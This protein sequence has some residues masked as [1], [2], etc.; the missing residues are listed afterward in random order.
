[1]AARPLR[2]LV[3]CNDRTC[4]ICD[5]SCDGATCSSCRCMEGSI[6]SAI[7]GKMVFLG[8]L[9]ALDGAPEGNTS[10][11]K[12]LSGLLD[13]NALA[14]TTKFNDAFMRCVSA[15]IKTDPSFVVVVVKKTGQGWAATL[16]RL[17]ADGHPESSVLSQELSAIFQNENTAMYKVGDREG[18][19]YYA[20]TS[21]GAGCGELGDKALKGE[22]LAVL[23]GLSA[24]DG[25]TGGNKE[26]AVVVGK[27]TVMGRVRNLYRV[28]RRK[29]LYV[30]VKGAMV[31]IKA[32]EAKKRP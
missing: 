28:G 20:I 24:T 3:A 19:E 8:R 9:D 25:V 7:A 4:K 31:P 17:S 23:R 27:R 26:K 13:D 2:R 29:G 18:L 14:Y 30:R 22:V 10:I 32:L 5:C 12:T 1:M 15:K 21:A 11:S 6:N 16:A